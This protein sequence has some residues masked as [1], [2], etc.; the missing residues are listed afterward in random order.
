MGDSEPSDS[1]LS[2]EECVAKT[3]EWRSH[4]IDPDLKQTINAEWTVLH[5]INHGVKPPP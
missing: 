3:R 4:R 1:D 2:L 5:S